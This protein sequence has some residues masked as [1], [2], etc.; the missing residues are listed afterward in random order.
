MKKIISLV[1]LILIISGEMLLVAQ[2]ETLLWEDNFDGTTINTNNWTIETDNTGG[3][4][5]ELQYYT[6]RN[7]NVYIDNGILILQALEEE[8]KEHSYT[9][10]KVTTLGFADWKY[11]RIEAKIKLPEGKG[12]WPAFWM[13]PTDEKY[14]TWPNSGEIDI[15]ELIGSDPTTVFGTI[16]YGPPWNYTNGEYSLTEGKFSDA[17]HIFIL[18]WTEETMKWFVDGQLYSTKTKDDLSR[19]EQWDIFK[20]RFHIILNLAVGGNWP[21]DPD[22]TTVFPQKMEIDYV[23]VFGD[24]EKQE[25]IAVDSAYANAEGVRYSIS[26][27]PGATFQWTVP[28]NAVISNGQGTSSIIVDWG[29]TPGNIS[30]LVSNMSCADQL[31]TH[32]VNFSSLIISG[33][34]HFFPLSTVTFSVPELSETTYQWSFPEDATLLSPMKDSVTVHWGC[35]EG[36]VKVDVSNACNDLSDTLSISLDDPRIYGPSTVSENRLNVIYTVDPIPESSFAWSVPSDATIT[37]GQGSDS[38]HAD[39]GVEGGVVSVEISNTCYTN[40]ID[41]PIRITDTLVLAD[42]ESS[43]LFFEPFSSTSFEEAANPVQDA[44]NA[45]P[46]VAKTLKSE[47]A[48]GGIYTDL[49]Y[50]LDMTKHKKFRMKVLGPKAGIVLLKIEDIDENVVGPLEVQAS[51]T[52]TSAWQE[53]EFIFPNA[54]SGVFDRLTLFFDFGSTQE[55]Y[56]YFDDIIHIPYSDVSVMDTDFDSHIAMYPNPAKDMLNFRIDHESIELI[57]IRDSLGRL[58]KEQKLETREGTIDLSQFKQGFYIVEFIS[59]KNKYSRILVIE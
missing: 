20:E 16:H 34:N 26:N 39:F 30:V 9:S 24:P 22:E 11:G 49:G 5:N 48:W 17:F 58:Q 54:S 23:R 41:L 46:N 56:Y 42:Y 10:G 44:V 18:E 4:N 32:S 31:Y 1:F 3:G 57:R 15:M 19:P 12:I 13:L 35:Q 27:I 7:T 14:G 2:C 59:T 53:L 8:Y 38:I 55:N 36:I 25:I 29:C 43:F 47:V 28:E 40:S 45:S 52:D 50:N 37:L 51:Y 6:P 33:T 21:G